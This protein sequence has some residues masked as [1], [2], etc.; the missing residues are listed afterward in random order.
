MKEGQ[1]LVTKNLYF[2]GLIAD[3]FQQP[4]PKTAIEEAFKKITKLGQSQGYE[5]GFQQFKRFMALM[6]GN[7]LEIIIDKNGES[8]VSIPIKNGPYSEKIQN[9]KP[10]QY[11]VRLNTGRI[12]WQGELT[13]RDLV[14]T[15]AFPETDMALAADT[16][17]FSGFMTREIK[18]LNGELVLRIVPELEG[19]CIELEK[20][21]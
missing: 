11:E 3:A 8:I 1:K 13:V 19:G 10:G 20:R 6:N 12:L 2:I 4:D 5:R 17:E 21:I 7:G 15:A 9:I 14:W 18:L 16:G